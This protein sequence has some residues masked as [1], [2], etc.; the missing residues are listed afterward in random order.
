MALSFR[1]EIGGLPV[2]LAP[3]TIA[4]GY[5]LVHK[6]HKGLLALCYYAT[7]LQEGCPH[8]VYACFDKLDIVW[9]HSVRFH[10]LATNGIS[11]KLRPCL[12]E[13]FELFGLLWLS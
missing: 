3:H 9:A 11:T 10:N 12:F 8:D 13:L 5:A 6:G 7:G 4:A 1:L 2:Q